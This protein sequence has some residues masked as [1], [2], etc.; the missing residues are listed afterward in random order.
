MATQA[1]VDVLLKHGIS[2]DKIE[3]YKAAFKLFDKKNTGLITQDA[4]NEL[5]VGEF[6][7]TQYGPDDIAYMLRQFSS[8]GG[9]GQG[10][11]FASFALSLH[12]RMA[13]PRY[14]EAFADAFDLFDSGKSGELTKSDLIEGMQKLGETLTDAEAEE[15]M[16]FAKKKDDFVRAMTASMAG[17]GGGSS[18]AGAGAAAAAPAAAAPA[19]AQ[20][21]P[22][23][24][25]AAAAPSTPG[26]GPPRP[27]GPGPASSPG[28][29]PRPG[30]PPRPAG[31]PA[32]PGAT[33][34]PRP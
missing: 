5:L 15:M 33:G 23:A 24:A 12:Q 34:S 7:Q 17:A 25:A 2:I 29:P 26:G 30:G 11:N 13:D 18:G 8:D 22:A 1:Q 10:V 16:K 21:A 4:I 14:N 20:A 31:P 3:E 9:Q 32:S 19:A 6:G 27:A 28:A